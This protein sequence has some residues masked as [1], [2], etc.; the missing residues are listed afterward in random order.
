ML[1][2]K[3][4]RVVLADDYIPFRNEL[5]RFLVEIVGADVIG[6]AND[7]L[8]LLSLL[9]KLAPHLII[10]DI[11]VPN[12]TGMEGISQ[13]NKNY[14]CVKVLVLTM[15]RDNQLFRQA[16]LAGAKG[17]LS[18]DD[19]DELMPAIEVIREGGVYIPRFI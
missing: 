1:M 4:Y 7:G 2:P 13:I 10:L 17:Y 11:T 8:E 3:P 18:K 14:P 5:K 16:I 9:N 12:L 19:L 15:H 6:E